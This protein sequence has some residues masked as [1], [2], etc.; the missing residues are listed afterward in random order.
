MPD[1]IDHSR[2]SRDVKI[3]RS[4]LVLTSADAISA[5][6]GDPARQPAYAH[7]LKRACDAGVL[8]RCRVICKLI[9]TAAEPSARRLSRQSF[10]V[11]GVGHAQRCGVDDRAKS[12]RRLGVAPRR[13]ERIRVRNVGVDLLTFGRVGD[14][15]RREE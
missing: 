4:A 12:S 6:L 8:D 14:L 3:N 5:R 1:A 10:G 15:N 7:F 2:S 9:L 11:N 13:D